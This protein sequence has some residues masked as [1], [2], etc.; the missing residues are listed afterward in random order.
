MSI[1]DE[2]TVYECHDT[3]VTIKK[4]G[5]VGFDYNTY[6]MTDEGF[7]LISS[8]VITITELER[9]NKLVLG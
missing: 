2:I 3:K 9:I 8:V 7:K 1:E 5:N 6:C 4:I